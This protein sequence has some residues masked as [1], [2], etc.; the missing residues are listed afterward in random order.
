MISTGLQVATTVVRWMIS[1]MSLSMT[2]LYAMY[3]A[4]LWFT[5]SIGYWKG[6][7]TDLTMKFMV[8]LY[9]L[10]SVGLASARL[11]SDWC[12]MLVDGRVASVIMGVGGSALLVASV[13]L[14]L[15]IVSVT[16]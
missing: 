5:A 2:F 4:V 15:P 12:P 9:V 16:P 10:P 3:V 14:C 13:L 1:A 11:G 7:P 6:Y 8:A